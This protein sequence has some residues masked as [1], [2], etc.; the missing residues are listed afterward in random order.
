MSQFNRV[1]TGRGLITSAAAVPSERHGCL[2]LASFP[3]SQEIA[4]FLSQTSIQ[5]A[6]GRGDKTHSSWLYRDRGSTTQ[7]PSPKGIRQHHE[8]L[9][10]A[11]G[12]K[13]HGVSS[14]FA[15]R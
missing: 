12:E 14:C 2:A 1:Y 3:V 11:R 8:M 5:M 9:S 7:I 6:A 10:H 15:A 13:W 4:S